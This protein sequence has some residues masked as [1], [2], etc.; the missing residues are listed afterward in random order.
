MVFGSS[1]PPPASPPPTST[2]RLASGIRYCPC[3]TPH[4]LNIPHQLPL[5]TCLLESE[6]FHQ[7]NGKKRHFFFRMHHSLDGES[8][9]LDASTA[10]HNVNY[11]RFFVCLFYLPIQTNKQKTVLENRRARW[12]TRDVVCRFFCLFVSRRNKLHTETLPSLCDGRRFNHFSG[13]RWH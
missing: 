10:R 4:R 2:L 13:R 11:S 1:P 12:R 3:F 9:R 7:R 5:P 8:A 6:S